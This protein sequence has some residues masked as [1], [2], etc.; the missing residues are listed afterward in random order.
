MPSNL[1]SLQQEE[2]NREHEVPLSKTF[3]GSTVK[4]SG[5]ISDIG[6]ESI[7]VFS[8]YFGYRTVNGRVKKIPDN[9][10]DNHYL[11]VFF[12]AF[13]DSNISRNDLLSINRGDMV[14][15]ECLIKHLTPSDQDMGSQFRIDFNGTVVSIQKTEHRILYADSLGHKLKYGDK[16]CFI[17]TVAY[18]NVDEIEV[19]ELRQYRDNVLS[20]TLAGR[21]FIE[22]YYAVSP[23]IAVIVGRS[24]I[25][26]A[27]IRYFIETFLIKK[28]NIS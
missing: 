14:E 9:G 1:T 19:V 16:A 2:W 18:G 27:M 3:I 7:G 13:I 26:K 10:K 23:Y 12:Y 20:K 25:L 4:F 6:A 24:L 15:F 21:T 22:F 17:A 8:N 5:I 28:R 11:K